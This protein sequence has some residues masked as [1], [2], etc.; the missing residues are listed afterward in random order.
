[1]SSTPKT[2]THS[3]HGAELLAENIQIR[4]IKLGNP[5]VGFLKSL[6]LTSLRSHLSADP[7]RIRLVENIGP[8]ILSTLSVEFRQGC[9][10]WM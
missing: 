7:F 10:A 1:M 4:V 2:T 8:M 6:P 9:I 5:V 3:G